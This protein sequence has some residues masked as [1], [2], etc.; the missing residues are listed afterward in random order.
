MLCVLAWDSKVEPFQLLNVIS[1]ED[2]FFLQ[3]G[4]GPTHYLVPPFLLE[5]GILGAK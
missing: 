5:A 1:F 3:G 2:D 4:K